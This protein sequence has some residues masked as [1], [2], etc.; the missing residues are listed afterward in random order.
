MNNIITFPS[1]VSML[2]V[3][4]EYFR[5]YAFLGFSPHLGCTQLEYYLL[6]NNFYRHL[7]IGP[8]IPKCDKVASFV[9]VNMV[10]RWLIT[11]MYM[12]RMSLRFMLT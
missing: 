9:W 11:P 10:S 6:P 3:G 4:R 12:L 7:A 8:G 5:H 1:C 2:Y